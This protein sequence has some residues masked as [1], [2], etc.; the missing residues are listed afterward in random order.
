MGQIPILMLPEPKLLTSTQTISTQI[1]IN[2]YSCWFL[3][4]CRVL[5]K[6]CQFLKSRAQ[7]IRETSRNTLVK[8]MESLGARY[9][10]YVLKELRS[11]LK[12]GYQVND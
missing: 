10:S 11:A 9:F 8:I 5:I 4:I 1:F 2:I 3:L 12:R 6:V 7:D